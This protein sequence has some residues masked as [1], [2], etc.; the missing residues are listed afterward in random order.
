MRAQFR[1]SDL[2]SAELNVEA[3]H[4][5][6]AV[7]VIA[8]SDQP[9]G[10]RCPECG[11][12]SRRVHSRYPRMIADLPCASRRMEL[13]LTVR[14]FVCNA[15][16]CHRKIFA[17]RFGDDIV[18]PMARRTARLERFRIFQN[19]SGFPNQV[20]SDSLMLAG[21]RPASYD[22]TIIE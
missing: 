21:R 4:Q 18:R 5:T 3:V 12:T 7:I 13:H 11:A 9:R 2:I 15:I 8:A 6:S 19:R 17:E 20:Y 16:Q 10:C 22:R 14:R 1:L